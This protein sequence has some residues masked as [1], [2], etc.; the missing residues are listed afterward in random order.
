M[1]KIEEHVETVKLHSM[2]SGYSKSLSAVHLIHWTTT[3]PSIEATQQIWI[4]LHG[5]SKLTEV[6]AAFRF[7]GN[8]GP[9]LVKTFAEV[10]QRTPRQVKK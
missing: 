6:A 10:F 1:S 4:C 2:Y 3:E 9:Q 7:A 8:E 5:H